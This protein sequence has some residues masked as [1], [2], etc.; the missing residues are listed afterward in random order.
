MS[1][2]KQKISLN[3]S[4][5]NAYRKISQ[6]TG[7]SD[8]QKDVAE[9][10]GLSQADLGNR[11]R[12]GSAAQFLIDWGAE[13]G[14]SAEELFPQLAQFN[15]EGQSQQGRFF[16]PP[17]WDGTHQKAVAVSRSVAEGIL[18]EAD[19]SYPEKFFKLFEVT[20]ANLLMP[21]WGILSGDMVLIDARS[22]EFQD[23][24]VYL[25]RLDG[26]DQPELLAVIRRGGGSLWIEHSAAS[27]EHRRLP[28]SARFLGRVVWRAGR[29]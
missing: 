8:T 20:D 7:C 13:N 26:S 11:K 19:R 1:Q 4:F 10:V 24:G 2:V 22:T 27:K 16:H 9:V 3:V 23:E 15:P 25:L 12:R 17:M 5:A 28:G 29:L 21:Y 18:S 6:L 14:I